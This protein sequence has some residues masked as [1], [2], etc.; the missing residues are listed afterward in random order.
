MENFSEKHRP[1]N[2]N[3]RPPEWRGDWKLEELYKKEIGPDLIGIREPHMDKG[4]MVHFFSQD[5]IQVM[6][7]NA[8]ISEILKAENLQIFH[9][10]G[11]RNANSNEP[12][13]HGWEIWGPKDSAMGERLRSLLP[14]IK[15]RA[16]ELKRKFEE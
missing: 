2:S 4:F 14:R 12:G 1:P 11:V 16:E 7:Y 3:K 15:Q 5:E 9:Q 8:S 13:Y 10:I 6:A